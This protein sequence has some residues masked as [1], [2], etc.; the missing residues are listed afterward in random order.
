M[1]LQAIQQQIRADADVLKRQL[2]AET[3]LAAGET[4]KDMRGLP[5]IAPLRLTDPETEP[6]PMPLEGG[7]YRYG[8]LARFDDESF[9][10]VAYRVLLRHGPDPEGLANYT[11]M[12]RAGKHKAEVLARLRYSHEG[13]AQKVRLRGLL[14]PAG[15]AGLAYIPL[16][17]RIIEWFVELALLSRTLGRMRRANDQYR[18]RANENFARLTKKINEQSRALNYWSERRPED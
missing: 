16:I 18:R 14:I 10:D 2:A 15:F 4:P 11:R 13:R 1:D 8:D 5:P 17:G 3:A 9:V 6:R 7:G 12:L